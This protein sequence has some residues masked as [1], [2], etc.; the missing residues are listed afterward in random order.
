VRTRNEH[1]YGHRF[2]HL[3]AEVFSQLPPQRVKTPWTLTP[4]MLAPYVASHR[5]TTMIAP[6][7]SILERPAQLVFGW[8]RGS[9]AARRLLFESS[10]RIFGARTFSAAGLPGRLFYRE[11]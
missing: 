4:E 6:L 5:N 10:W 11:S 7:R 9:R 3:L 2:S 1:T 8:Q